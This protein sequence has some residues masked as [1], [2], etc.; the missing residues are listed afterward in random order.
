MRC[1]VDGMATAAPTW[2]ST[3]SLDELKSLDRGDM[4]QAVAHRLS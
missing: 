2:N 1:T 4:N 3:V